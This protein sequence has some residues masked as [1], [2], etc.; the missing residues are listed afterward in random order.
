[1]STASR[2]Q[3]ISGFPAPPAQVSLLAEVDMLHEHDLAVIV[4]D[5]VIAVEPIA[6][7]IEIVS[8]LDAR[9]V[10]DAQDRLADLLRLKALSVVVDNAIVPVHCHLLFLLPPNS[11]S[12]MERPFR[13]SLRF[14]S[15]ITGDWK[16]LRSLP[17][18]TPRQDLS[19][20]KPWLKRKDFEERAG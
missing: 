14:P 16:S 12:K 11:A 7:L 1:M 3:R 17:S 6:V 2:V 8:A 9:V 4:L 10:L 20:Y 19:P 5:D 15:T 13:L 18:Q